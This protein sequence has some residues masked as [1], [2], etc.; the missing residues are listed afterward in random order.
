MRGASA[1]A[2]PD[3]NPEVDRHLVRLQRFCFSRI[4]GPASAGP[5]IW[6]APLHRQPAL[7]RRRP[8][9]DE[10]GDALPVPL[11]AGKAHSA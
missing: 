6:A 11:S 7:R 3:L 8:R 10:G 1:G 5:S 2:D 9:R 4:E